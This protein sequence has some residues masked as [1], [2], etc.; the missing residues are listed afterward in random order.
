MKRKEKNQR[1]QLGKKECRPLYYAAPRYEKALSCAD[2]KKDFLF[3]AGMCI[4]QHLCPFTRR[5]PG[6]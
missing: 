2:I 6:N 5:M 1:R 4:P 3:F